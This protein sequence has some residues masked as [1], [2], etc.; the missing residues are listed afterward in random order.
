MRRSSQFS[1]EGVGTTFAAR[2]LAPVATPKVILDFRARVHTQA[3]GFVYS[4]TLSI[5]IKSVGVIHVC[6]YT[7]TQVS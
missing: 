7:H 1:G 5:Q 6:W 2:Y 4:A 3:R